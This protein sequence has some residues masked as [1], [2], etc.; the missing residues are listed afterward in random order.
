[1]KVCFVAEGSYPYM[2][3]GISSWINIFM[4]CFPDYEFKTF[5]IGAKEKDK[6]KYMCKIADNMTKIEE[7]F[8]DTALKER[9]SWSPKRVI[10]SARD[11]EVLINHFSGKYSDWPLIFEIVSKFKSKEV[12]DFFNSVDF[13][14]IV[15]EIY[16]AEYK[17]AP[18]NDFLWS[19]RTMYLYQFHVLKGEVPEADI[20]HSVSAGFPGIVASKVAYFTGKPFVLTEHG[21]YTREREEEIIKNK[22]IK[23]YVK[24]LWIKYFHSM[25]QCAY[26]FADKI[27]TQFNRNR[28]I[29]IE[30]GADKR[31]TLIIPNGINVEEYKI[32][33][34]K[35]LYGD[36]I[37]AGAIARIVPIKDIVTMIK[38]FEKAKQRVPKLKLVL[39]GP[40]NED[41]VYHSYVM[42]Y[43]KKRHIDDVIF[44][45][46]V[47][48]DIYIK[49][50][51]SMDIVLLTSIS[52][53]QPLSLLEAMSANKPIIT[54]DV[55]SCGELIL[56]SNDY[57][58]EAGIVAPVMDYEAIA[59]AIVRLAKDSNLREKMGQAGR[60]RASTYYTI[61]NM[62]K[63]Y[64]KLYEELVETKK[65]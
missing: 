63:C 62:G 46:R 18:F 9:V 53:A 61:E 33:I 50:L 54:T 22:A 14:D 55:G 10:K 56:G 29:E 65:K 40:D 21:I 15:R 38:A 11:K 52:E 7:C 51:F 6:G 64:R 23:D 35:R 17:Y 1:M 4:K 44:T 31:K 48:Y 37:V 26:I 8:L 58:G 20:Y 49:S 5:S 60:K 16:D 25:S 27:V 32:T 34:D 24:D 45:G 19:M 2:I 36:D 57:I 43:V 41:V 28:E 59:D 47:N 42:D 39:V 12:I 30:A 3:G 13:F